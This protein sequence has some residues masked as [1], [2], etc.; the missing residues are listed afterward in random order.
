M[1]VAAGAARLLDERESTG[2][3]DNHLARAVVE[4][5]AAHAER[6]TMAHAMTRLARPHG[7][8]RMAN[9]IVALL[10]QAQTAAV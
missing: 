5:T 3:F 10:E 7:T 8:R 4:L 6:A 9:S 2:R 1:F